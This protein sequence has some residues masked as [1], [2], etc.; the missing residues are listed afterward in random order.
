MTAARR[1]CPH[2]SLAPEGGAYNRIEVARTARI[3]PAI[4][5]LFEQGAITLTALRLLAPHLTREP[6]RGP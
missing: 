4:L 2:G 3:Y 5:E 6:R 1:S